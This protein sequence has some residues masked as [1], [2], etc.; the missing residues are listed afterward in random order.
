MLSL[1]FSLLPD[2]TRSLARTWR[3]QGVQPWHIHSAELSFVSIP[4]NILVEN[5]A[6]NREHFLSTPQSNEVGIGYRWRNRTRKHLLVFR[7]HIG[8]LLKARTLSLGKL[9]KL[10]G[11]G[12]ENTQRVIGA[13]IV[14]WGTSG[15]DE[16]DF[17]E[18]RGLSEVIIFARRDN[19]IVRVKRAYP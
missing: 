14:G 12:V 4:K 10:I 19:E 15:I 8:T 17:E 9:F 11:E 1:L 5:I 7:L 18:G 2:I 16:C 13:N 6:E 3:L